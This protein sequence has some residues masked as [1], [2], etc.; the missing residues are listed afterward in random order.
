MVFMVVSS[1]G[2]AQSEGERPKI[3]TVC[4]VLANASQYRDAAI[5]IVGRLVRRVGTIDGFE[6][7]TQDGCKKPV[8]T[9]KHIWPNELLISDLAESDLPQPPTVHPKLSTEIVANKLAA[10]RRST[11]L[12]THKEPI[13]SRKAAKVPNQWAVVYGRV[14]I[15]PNLGKEPCEIGSGGFIGAPMIIMSDSKNIRIL[16]EDGTENRS[17]DQ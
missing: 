1:L 3:L 14:F 16:S 5:A 13:D 6:F 12:G 17:S 7:L 9:K 15:P 8:V 4:E 2:V 10:V 11:R